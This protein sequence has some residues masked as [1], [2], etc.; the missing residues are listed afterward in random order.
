MS[1]MGDLAINRL[2]LEAEFIGFLR[3]LFLRKGF[4]FVDETRTWPALGGTSR[5]CCW[6][7]MVP[8]A[9]LSS[10][11]SFTTTIMRRPSCFA[12]PSISLRAR[13][14]R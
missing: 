3:Q 7:A 12:A 2:N 10:N 13:C 5:I 8:K 11:S 9:A 1:R 4:A 6:T 14:R